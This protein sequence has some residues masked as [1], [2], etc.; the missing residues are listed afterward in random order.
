MHS[1]GLLVSRERLVTSLIIANSRW[2]TVVNGLRWN[3]HH[4]SLVVDHWSGNVVHIVVHRRRDVMGRG[5]V[6]MVVMVLVV[7]RH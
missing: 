6:M 7:V 2:L 3:L 1:H 5:F 4:W